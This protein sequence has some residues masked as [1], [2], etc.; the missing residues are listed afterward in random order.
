MRYRRRKTNGRSIDEHR[1]V[2][3]Q[4]LGRRLNHNEY[5]HHI[6]GNKLD[7]RIENLQVMTP[8]EHA[9]EHNQK[10]SITKICAVCR[11]EFTPHKTKRK[12][13]LTCSEECKV[14]AISKSNA[15]KL[16]AETA[17][18]IKRRRLA[19]ES[20]RKLAIEFGVTETSVSYIAKG[21]TWKFV[22]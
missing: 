16:N 19:G 13:Q 8:Q 17:G 12:R 22:S 7:N 14:V 6:N 4:C 3:E 1:L 2:M 15:T 9:V 10:Y 18:E 5:V 21:K 20:L 11:K